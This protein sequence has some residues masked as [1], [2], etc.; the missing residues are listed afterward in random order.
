M[1]PFA[2]G[3]AFLLAL[4][5]CDRACAQDHRHGWLAVMDDDTQ[6]ML[7]RLSPQGIVTSILTTAAT[8]VLDSAAM[9]L[10]NRHCVVAHAPDRMLRLD[11]SGAIVQTIVVGGARD[12]AHVDLDRHGDYLVLDR[13]MPSRLLG[14]DRTTFAVTTLHGSVGNTANS[15]VRDVH[16]GDLAIAGLDLFGV[17]WD[18][19]LVNVAL[20]PFPGRADQIA[21]DLRIRAVVASLDNTGRLLF[22]RVPTWSVG[23]ST[24]FPAGAAIH[25]DRTSSVAPKYVL[26]GQK[27][28][29]VVEATS[30]RIATLWEGTARFRHVVPYRGRNLATEAV[31]PGRWDV[32]LSVPEDAGLRYAIAL[33]GLPPATSLP[34]ADGRRIPF[35]VDGLTGASLI[36]ALGSRFVGNV[37]VLDASGAAR[38]SIDVRGLGSIGGVPLW[39]CAVTIDPAAPAGLRT[40]IDPIVLRL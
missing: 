21:F 9:D 28:L 8:G 12:L 37:G 20:R 35:A 39:L 23:Y 34:L 5:A 17:R 36:G 32:R 19:T 2:I 4:F 33:S 38:A 25:A 18:Y 26:G 16:S 14:V 11:A 7:A 22:F 24:G 10:D 29:Y 31:G 30:Q 40:I 3:F 13:G 1:R 15:F 27:G 6:S